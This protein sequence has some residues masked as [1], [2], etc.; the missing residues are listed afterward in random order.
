[1][2]LQTTVQIKGIIDGEERICQFVH[3][4]GPD[5]VFRGRTAREVFLQSVPNPGCKDIQEKELQVYIEVQRKC[6]FGIALF[7]ENDPQEASVK[8]RELAAKSEDDLLDMVI[9]DP[10]ALF[11]SA[12]KKLIE[13]DVEG[14]K[15][16]SYTFETFAN[17]VLGPEMPKNIGDKF[18]CTALDIANGQK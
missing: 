10:S 14:A 17:L 8:A 7:A 6:S 15:A 1:M 2:T 12:V 18:L 13:G 16:L 9:P 5:A 3:D 4:E 11:A